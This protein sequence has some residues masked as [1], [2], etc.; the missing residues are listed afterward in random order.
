MAFLPESD[1]Q[2]EFH[3]QL[4]VK[5]PRRTDNALFDVQLAVKTPRCTDN[6]QF[7]VQ[8]AVQTPRWTETVHISA[9]EAS[10]NRNGVDIMHSLMFNSQNYTKQEHWTVRRLAAQSPRNR[11]NAQVRCLVLAVK[12]SRGR[13]NAQFDVSQFT[14]QERKRWTVRV[15]Q[16]KFQARETV[17]SN[18]NLHSS[19]FSSQN[20][21]NKNGAMFIYIAA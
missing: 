7:D 11:N 15:P 6:A 14:L 4:A 18:I 10:R 20:S 1:T 5:T 8:L 9:V 17:H 13:N 12:N 2:S 16:S 19:T 3:V 21:R